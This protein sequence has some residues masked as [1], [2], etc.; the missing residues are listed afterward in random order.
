[1][2]LFSQH[3]RCPFIYLLDSEEKIALE[4]VVHLQLKT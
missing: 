2:Q 4:Q 3:Y 1:M